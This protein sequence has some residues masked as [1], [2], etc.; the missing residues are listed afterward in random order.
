M[1]RRRK[2]NGPRCTQPASLDDAKIRNFFENDI[3][4][5]ESD[6]WAKKRKPWPTHR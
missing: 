1:A 3:I 2:I 4:E 5:Y 6:D